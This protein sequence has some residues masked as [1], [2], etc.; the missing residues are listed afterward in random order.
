MRRVVVT[1]LGAITPIGNNI[2]AMWE[3]VQNGVCGI[4]PITQYDTSE[5]KVKLAGEVKDYNPEDYLDKNKARKMSRFAQFAVI[6]SNERVK[7]SPHVIYTDTN[8]NPVRL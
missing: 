5:R 6:A 8:R 4:A 7:L 2:E 1:G 3:S